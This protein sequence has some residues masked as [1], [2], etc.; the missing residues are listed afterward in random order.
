MKLSA[1]HVFRKPGHEV[2]L[3]RIPTQPPKGMTKERARARV[4]TL[5]EELFSLQDALW[6]SKLDG[7]LVV[8]QGRDGAGKDGAIKN[9]AGYLNPRGVVVHSFGVPTAEERAHDFL[10]R[11]HLRTPARGE[12]TL[13]N[14]SHYEDVLVARVHELVPKKV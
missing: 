11:I 14:R 4:D 13:F 1:E 9:V 7:V 5:G 3:N 8:L 6:G 12:V 10:W 2:R